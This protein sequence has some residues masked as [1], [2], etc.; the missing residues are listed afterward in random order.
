MAR[1]IAVSKITT[2]ITT[3]HPELEAPEKFDDWY[4]LDVFLLVVLVF[5][6]DDNAFSKERFL[7]I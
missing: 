2:A 6:D 7:F 1:P 4:P 5:L 3:I